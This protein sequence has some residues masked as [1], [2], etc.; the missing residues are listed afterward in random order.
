MV[1]GGGRV[2]SG[3]GRAPG[4]SQPL[5]DGADAERGC[6]ASGRSG[7]GAPLRYPLFPYYVSCL[8]FRLTAL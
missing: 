3:G 8:V 1:V 6:A 4:L 2:G 5:R 7:S